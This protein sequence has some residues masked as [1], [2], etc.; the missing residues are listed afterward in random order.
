MPLLPDP[1]QA[2]LLNAGW[3]RG[4]P[5]QSSRHPPRGRVGRDSHVVGAVLVINQMQRTRHRRDVNAAW[6]DEER[7]TERA[8]GAR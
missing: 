1:C 5:A 8:G 2:V 4:M 7:R 3:N 6:R